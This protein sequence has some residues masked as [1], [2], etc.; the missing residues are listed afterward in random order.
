MHIGS[1]AMQPPSPAVARPGTSRGQGKGCMGGPPR[2]LPP[3]IGTS[4]GSGWQAAPA[5]APAYSR[6][7]WLLNLTPRT[8]AEITRQHGHMHEAVVQGNAV[9][10]Q[11]QATRQSQRLIHL[12]AQRNLLPNGERATRTGVK[13][14]GTTPLK[15]QFWNICCILDVL[16]GGEWPLQPFWQFLVLW[17]EGDTTW[18]E[19]SKLMGCIGFPAVLQ[20]LSNVERIRTYHE[21]VSRSMMGYDHPW[22]PKALLNDEHNFGHDPLYY[23]RMAN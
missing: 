9:G 19:C 20:H 18:E 15:H 5:A 11:M 17:E 1:M 6:N 16:V 10:R 22:M 7:N 23:T 21:H 3:D 4:T 12:L 14:D 13:L 2:R 8:F